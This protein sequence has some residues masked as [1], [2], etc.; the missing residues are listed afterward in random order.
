MKSWWS[1]PT[2]TPAER[3]ARAGA[4]AEYETAHPLPVP[5]LRPVRTGRYSGYYVSPS[6]HHHFYGGQ[7]DRRVCAMAARA[8]L[9]PL[10]DG[11]RPFQRDGLF[12]L[13]QRGIYKID[14]S[15][16][17]RFRASLTSALEGEITANPPAADNEQA[18]TPEMR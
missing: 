15:T 6:G 10:P 1:I 18:G 2:R 8:D 13:G 3:A 4:K 12:W 9:P 16:P 14:L 5:E 17:E 11:L 7:P